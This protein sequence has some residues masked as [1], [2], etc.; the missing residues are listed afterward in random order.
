LLV[1]DKAGTDV[2]TVEFDGVLVH[3]GATSAPVAPSGIYVPEDGDGV[4]RPNNGDGVALGDLTE[5]APIWAKGT[6]R[7]VSEGKQ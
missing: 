5:E 6:N 4:E 7:A 2:G 3:V 1:E